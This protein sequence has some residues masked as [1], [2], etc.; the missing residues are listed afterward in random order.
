MAIAN[1]SFV[2]CSRAGFNQKKSVFVNLR[3]EVVYTRLL[4]EKYVDQWNV[5]RAPIPKISGGGGT[6]KLSEAVVR[7]ALNG[8]L[9]HKTGTE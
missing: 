5:G 1:S 4:S 8:R 2:S 9:F 6:S 3:K 7:S